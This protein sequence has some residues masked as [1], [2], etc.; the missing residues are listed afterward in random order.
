M[1]VFFIISVWGLYKAELVI[2]YI[3]I[4]AV[5]NLIK[6]SVKKTKLLQS[7]L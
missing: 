2:Y 6:I 7:T 3:R 4:K 1:K 5:C